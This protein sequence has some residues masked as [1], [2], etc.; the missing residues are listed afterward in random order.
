LLSGKTGQ[1]FILVLDN[2]LF[3]VKLA[4]I[5]YFE[6]K[7]G[8]C[9]QNGSQLQKKWVGYQRPSI[10]CVLQKKEGFDGHKVEQMMILFSLLGESV[11]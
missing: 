9:P 10:F 4:K 8:V 6:K 11:T 3:S 7:L 1:T 5:R 2:R